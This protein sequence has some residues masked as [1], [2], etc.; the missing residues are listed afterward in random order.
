MWGWAEYA[1]I[2]VV[3]LIPITIIMT[4]IYN[5]SG[6]NLLCTAIFHAG[7]NTFPFVLPYA[8]PVFVLVFLWAGY[9]VFS[10]KMWRRPVT[11][12]TTRG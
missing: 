11:T 10:D 2:R 5:R 7:M 12:A 9:A 6:G 1:E 8:P 4:W 3:F